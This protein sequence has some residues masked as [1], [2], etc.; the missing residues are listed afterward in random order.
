MENLAVME[1]RVE[2]LLGRALRD[3]DRIEDAV[4]LQDS[5]RKKSVFLKSNVDSTE[6]IR[7]WRE[8]RWS[9]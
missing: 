2:M 3:N 8:S 9:S 4:R 5:L 1:K 7:R 6:F